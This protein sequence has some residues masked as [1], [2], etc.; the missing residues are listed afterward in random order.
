MTGYQFFYMDT[1]RARELSA[2]SGPHAIDYWQRID[3]VA[4]DIATLMQDMKTRGADTA[5]VQV[6]QTPAPGE[7]IYLAENFLRPFTT[8]RQHQARVAGTRSP[9]HSRSAIAFERPGA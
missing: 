9:C 4:Q 5:D 7:T 3:D 2:D 6:F 8:T 1:R